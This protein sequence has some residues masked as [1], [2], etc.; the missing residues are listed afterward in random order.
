[1]VLQ[2]DVPD[3]LSGELERDGIREEGGMRGRRDE[4][5]EG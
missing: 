5:K 2:T 4:R 1:V 3:E